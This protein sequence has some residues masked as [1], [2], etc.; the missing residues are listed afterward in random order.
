MADLSA[1]I[2]KLNDGIANNTREIKSLSSSLIK[3]EA[4]GVAVLESTLRDIRN[5]LMQMAGIE[6]ERFEYEKER[7]VLE[8]VLPDTDSSPITTTPT[9]RSGLKPFSQLFD[10]SFLGKLTQSISGS[11]S[12]FG[13]LFASGGILAIGTALLNG[14]AGLGMNIIPLVLGAIGTYM[15]ARGENYNW[16]NDID[17]SL[18]GMGFG[19]GLGGAI[20]LFLGG[21]V[22]RIIGTLLGG[23]AGALISY[24]WDEFVDKNNPFKAENW[25]RKYNNAMG[26][27]GIEDTAE[28][29][30]NVDLEISQSDVAP[31]PTGFESLGD[32]QL[33]SMSRSTHAALNSLMAQPTKQRDQN[34][35]TALQN[36]LEMLDLEI[37]RR[38]SSTPSVPVPLPKTTSVAPPAVPSQPISS[39]ISDTSLTQGV[40]LVKMF[41]EELLKFAMS[42]PIQ[43]QVSSIIDASVRTNNVSSQTVAVK[44]RG[45]LDTLQPG[46]SVMARN[47]IN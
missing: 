2:I 16:E 31:K 3:A 6:K 40:D 28:D 44:G 41:N 25:K 20:G 43:D 47:A 36:Q 35:I 13:A 34:A 46:W 9:S 30:L 26:M 42:N 17:R 22:G 1:V 14:V 33:S 10:E 29:P 39:T 21:P 8:G 45:T 18:T 12:G 5:I 37:Q 4:I 11:A 15:Y 38:G 23:I 19:M 27:L 7:L 24:N 32:D